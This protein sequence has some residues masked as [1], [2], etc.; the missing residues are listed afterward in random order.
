VVSERCALCTAILLILGQYG[1]S[2]CAVIVTDG[3][4][5]LPDPQRAMLTMLVS[6]P[7]SKQ[8]LTAIWASQELL[9]WLVTC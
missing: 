6:Q 4:W 8:R 3:R 2:F 1:Q 7:P 5:F 9:R